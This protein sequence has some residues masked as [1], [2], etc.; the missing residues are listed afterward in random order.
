MN[1][2]DDHIIG[3]YKYPC[4]IKRLDRFWFLHDE[5]IMNMDWFV[6]NNPEY[7]YDTRI[8]INNKEIVLEVKVQRSDESNS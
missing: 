8:L 7:L 5:M 4:P 2:E 6:D 1:N 3:T